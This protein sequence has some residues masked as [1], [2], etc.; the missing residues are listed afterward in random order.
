ML[1]FVPRL[2]IPSKTDK[3]W[4]KNSSWNPS[5]IGKP[6]YAAYSVLANCVGY[7][8]GRWLEL[9]VRHGVPYATIKKLG[10]HNAAIYWS[11]FQDGKVFKVGQAPKLGAIIVWK[12]SGAGHMAVVEQIKDNGDIVV[13]ASH[14]NGKAFSLTTCKKSNKYIYKSGVTT[15]GFIYFPVELQLAYM[16][17]PVD[18]NTTVKQVEVIAPS[19]NVRT[20]AGTSFP[21]LISGKYIAK[22]IY[23]ILSEK[24]ANGYV[25]GEV[26]IGKWI[27]ISNSNWVTILE[28]EN[29]VIPP[30]EPTI[31]DEPEN[32]IG[33]ILSN[34]ESEINSLL[35]QYTEFI[36]ELQNIIKNL[37]NQNNSIFNDLVNSWGA[38]DG[39]KEENAKLGSELAT[40]QEIIDKIIEIAKGA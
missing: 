22:G 12:T 19:L 7:V 39:L 24:S 38:I 9:S 33:E 23:N 28:T 35:G 29:T 40:K 17:V 37:T 10:Q 36:N 1:P 31:P 27:A 15:L 2:T 18:R 5:I 8:W 11:K 26:E 30:I 20:G 32:N 25:W 16:P 3:N 34:T 4:L 6:L 14:Y 13:S 21:V